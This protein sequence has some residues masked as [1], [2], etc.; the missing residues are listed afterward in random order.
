VTGEIT[1][2]DGGFNVTVGGL[3]PGE[4]S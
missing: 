1:F 4:A 3:D 2:V